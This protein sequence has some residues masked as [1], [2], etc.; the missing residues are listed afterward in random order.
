EISSCS[1]FKFLTHAEMKFLS[2]LQAT[3]VGLCICARHEF[4]CPNGAG[5]LQ[6]SE[7]YA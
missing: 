7:W 2:N 3:G 4:V 6:K 1:G 5:D